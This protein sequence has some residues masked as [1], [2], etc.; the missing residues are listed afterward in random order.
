MLCENG[1]AAMTR[2]EFK[3][4]AQQGAVLLDG[5]TGS[6]LREHGMP[7]GV[8]TELWALEHPEVVTEMQ[9]GYIDAGSRIIY[10]PTFGA[11]RIGLALHG[12]EDRLEE[13]NAGC[14]AISR[15]AAEGRAWVAGDMTTTGRTLEP[16]GDISDNEMFEVYAEQA[17][18]LAAAG[19]DLL[20]IETMLSL[21]ETI[22][23]LE[24][25]HSVCEL[26]VMCSMTVMADGAL[27][28]GGT[29]DEAVA[30]LQEVG[31]D[32]VGLNCSVGPDQLE[33]VVSA[34]KAVAEVPLIVKPN[35]GIPV[36]DEQG[37]A[38]YSMTP[39]AFAAAMKKLVWRG[40]RI[41]G[42]CCGTDSSYIRALKEAVL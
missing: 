8:S 2:D 13:I 22:I 33:A 38:H 39:E 30:T 41:I 32:A 21:E 7:V 27:Y 26:P 31:A 17:G 10:A 29:I 11:N 4:L 23:A 28:M 20:V 24:A 12:L 37:N 9:R 5:A 25:A 14:V 16:A 19:A 35:A 15:R 1:G 42:G 3:T 6:Y 18:A 34:M 36:M 40:A